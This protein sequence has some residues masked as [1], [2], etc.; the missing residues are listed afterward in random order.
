M[1]TFILL[2]ALMAVLSCKEHKVSQNTSVSIANTTAQKNDNSKPLKNP[3]ELVSANE[4]AKI[5]GWT[6]YSKGKPN[7]M[8]SEKLKSCGFETKDSGT[9]TLVFM[10][11]KG[12][13]LQ[14]AFNSDISK[15]NSK[16]TYQDVSNG[17]GHQMVYCYGQDGPHYLYKIRW[18]YGNHT[19]KSIEY[20]A[21]KRQNKTVTLKKLKQIASIIN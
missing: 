9:L 10:R 8:N 2:T 14:S 13:Y 20:R 15:D 6:E 1:R 18:R 7:A 17:T 5:I 12:N 21:L 19:E 11:H 4:I 3:C 16:L